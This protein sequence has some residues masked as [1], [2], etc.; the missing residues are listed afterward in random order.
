MQ[1]REV[2]RMCFMQCLNVNAMNQFCKANR[3]KQIN[4]WMNSNKNYYT[5][6]FE[7]PYS[8]LNINRL[9]FTCQQHMLPRSILPNTLIA[10]APLITEINQKLSIYRH[11]QLNSG[12]PNGIMPLEGN[13]DSIRNSPYHS[14]PQN[15]PFAQKN[16]RQNINS[17]LNISV[18]QPKSQFMFLPFLLVA[19][20]PR[21]IT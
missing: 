1:S 15:A 2:L 10:H 9:T 16:T 21:A 3:N 12:Y 8:S 7:V 17:H 19:L 18:H 13:K 11:T 14:H 5:L 20:N 6:E 4:R